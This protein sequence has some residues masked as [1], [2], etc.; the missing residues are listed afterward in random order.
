MKRLTVALALLVVVGMAQDVWDMEEE[1]VPSVHTG[2]VTAFLRN[3]YT[4]SSDGTDSEDLAHAFKKDYDALNTDGR[5]GVTLNA[6]YEMR[7]EDLLLSVRHTRKM[8]EVLTILET[9]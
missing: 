7:L 2:A 5:L 8:R 6:L 9:L 4:A 3:V 1:Y